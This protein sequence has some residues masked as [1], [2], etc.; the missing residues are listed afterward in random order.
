MVKFAARSDIHIRVGDAAF[1]APYLRIL[2]TLCF[3]LSASSLPWLITASGNPWS[4][5]GSGL[6]RWRYG[7]DLRLGHDDPQRLPPG[8]VGYG[9]ELSDGQRAPA[10]GLDD[11]DLD[12]V[13]G[14]D[15]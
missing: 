13:A 14:A 8:R 9:V 11:F 7:P 4:E 3:L 15:L 6:R 5:R 1:A 10:V 12:A 2:R